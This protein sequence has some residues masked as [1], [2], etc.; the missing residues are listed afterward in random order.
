M[1]V[2]SVGHLMN[3]LIIF[4]MAPLSIVRLVVVK[5]CFHFFALVLP[6]PPF[7]LNFYLSNRVLVRIKNQ[8]SPSLC[9]RRFE[10]HQKPLIEAL[11]FQV[12]VF[13]FQFLK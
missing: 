6:I 5:T 1:C 11:S 12:F 4:T 13:C 7:R 3:L 2:V 10:I 9:H 8:L